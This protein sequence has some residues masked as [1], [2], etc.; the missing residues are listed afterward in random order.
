MRAAALLP[1]LLV[2]RAQAQN[3]SCG[4]KPETHG[5]M[6]VTIDG[7]TSEVKCFSGEVRS[8]HATVLVGLDEGLVLRFLS[9]PGT[10]SCRIPVSV[11]IDYHTRT[12]LWTAYSSRTNEF[13]DCTVTQ[14]KTASVW[15]GE[16]TADLVNL[17]GNKMSGSPSL[18]HSEKDSSG[19]PLTKRVNV[20]WNFN[21]YGR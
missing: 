7:Q 21:S 20:S 14:R 13:G 5:V 17:K 15:R 2:A 6:T 12:G 11:G 3:A 8:G 10:Q 9:H 1:L 19:K 16:V 18:W 4:L